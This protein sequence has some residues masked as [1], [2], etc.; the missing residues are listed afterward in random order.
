LC[1][2]RGVAVVL[3]LVVGVAVVAGVSYFRYRARQARIRG[4]A[5]LAQRIGFTFTQDDVDHVVDMPFALFSKGDGRKVELIVA[6]THNGLPM[7]MF[8]Y[9]YYDDSSNGGGRR[10]RTYHRFTCAVIQIPA[11][12]PPLCLDHEDFLTR[13][14]SHV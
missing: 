4:V 12:C 1:K 11:A 3:L 5:A 2:P 7:R 10:S 8:D 14:G 9:W 6:G 13:L